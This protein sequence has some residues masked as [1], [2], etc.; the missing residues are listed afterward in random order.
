MNKYKRIFGSGPS[1]LLISALLFTV[2]RR[3]NNYLGIRT[4]FDEES[5]LPVLLFLLLTT[6]C[7]LTVVW[8]IK[9][10]NPKRRGVELITGGPFRYVRHPLYAAFLS[11]FNLGL[12]FLLNSP[13]FI[14][15][16][17]LLHPLWHLVIRKEESA[18]RNI[19][20]SEYDKYCSRTGRFI[21]RLWTAHD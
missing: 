7:V 14:V 19:F 9:T 21:P 2:T 8:S 20:G 13:L 15:W 16:A 17:V 4:I 3:L 10:L 12:A 6:A 1:G 18:L 5:M 11:L